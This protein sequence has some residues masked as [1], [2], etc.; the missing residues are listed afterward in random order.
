MAP[1]SGNNPWL[2]SPQVPPVLAKGQMSGIQQNILD[3]IHPEIKIRASEWIEY[4][5]PEGKSYYF[6]S[7]TQQSV[8]D[9]PTALQELEG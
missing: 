5:T 4:K 2:V 8:W 1:G 3:L 6:S 7:K 9:K